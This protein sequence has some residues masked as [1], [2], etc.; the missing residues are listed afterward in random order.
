[1][2]IRYYR[3]GTVSRLIN[4]VFS[5]YIKAPTS[6]AQD[7]K[8][9]NFTDGSYTIYYETQKRKVFFPAAPIP[10]VDS[11]YKRATAVLSTEDDIKTNTTRVVY[12]NGTIIIRNKSDGFYTYEVQPT[13]FF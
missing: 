2:T 11:P 13:S 5:S 10:G 6:F 4:Q 3:N 12:R 7:W 1:M 9:V 8:R